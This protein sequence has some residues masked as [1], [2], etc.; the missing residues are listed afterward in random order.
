VTE[1]PAAVLVVAGALTRVARKY[2]DFAY[3]V[4]LLDAGVA[5]GQLATVA[6]TL[7]LRAVP[8]V[9][10][11][12]DAALETFGLDGYAEPIAA[13]VALAHGEPCP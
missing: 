6:D 5:V 1:D 8:A 12:D 10:W 9:D 13:V 2:F 3:K 4:C 11:A 7:G